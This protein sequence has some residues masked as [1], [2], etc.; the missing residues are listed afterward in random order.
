LFIFAFGDVGAS[1]DN[2]I[3]IIIISYII[4]AP[5]LL[6]LFSGI[7]RKLSARMQARVGPPLIQ[8]IYDILKLL[9]KEN[10]V[11]RKSQN[12]YIYFF[13]AAIVFA[14]CLFFSGQNI[15]MAIFALTLAEIFFVLGAYKASSPYSIIGAQRELIQMIAYEPILILS[16]IGI[17]MLTDSFY[18]RDIV[19]YKEPLVIYLPGLF[20]ALIFILAL[21]FRKSPFDLSMSEHAHQE[22]VRGITTEFSGRAL[23]A[24]QIAHWYDQAIALG[25]VYLF[26]ANNLFLGLGAVAIAYLLVIFIDNNFARFRWQLVLKSSWIIALVLGI[27]NIMF[28]FYLKR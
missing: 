19:A 1:I 22:L 27:G 18:L 14:G 13:L 21:K 9:E 25:F 10:L 2:K 5:A 6:A 4:F 12:L 23:A 7:D 28:L 24:I 17:E 15:L 11:V 16:A 8:P 3:A 20:M 26:F